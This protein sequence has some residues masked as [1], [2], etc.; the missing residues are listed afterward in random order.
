MYCGSLARQDWP[1]STRATPQSYKL[2]RPEDPLLLPPSPP[3]PTS[4]PG[5]VRV[6]SS[7]SATPGPSTYAAPLLLLLPTSNPPTP[8]NLCSH[9]GR[10]PETS[11]TWR[12]E[13]S[14]RDVKDWDESA[15]AWSLQSLA[16]SFAQVAHVLT[17]RTGPFKLTGAGTRRRLE[18][19]SSRRARICAHVSLGPSKSIIACQT[20]GFFRLMHDETADCGNANG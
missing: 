7:A 1:R 14:M 8:S 10:P 6:P 5:P 15:L 16:C 13:T 18:P 12:F 20:S 11:V 3:D 17:I 2:K 19:A 4:P 9:G